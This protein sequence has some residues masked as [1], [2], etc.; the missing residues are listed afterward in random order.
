MNQFIVRNNLNNDY[1]KKL[2]QQD[3]FRYI[4]NL[5]KGQITYD[6]KCYIEL[7]NGLV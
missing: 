4:N 1:R 2:K 3:E 6:S 7:L 5:F